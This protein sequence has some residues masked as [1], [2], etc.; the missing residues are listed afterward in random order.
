M[1]TL[2]PA[3]KIKIL[4][5]N[6]LPLEPAHMFFIK[7]ITTAIE[8]KLYQTVVELRSKQNIFY[9]IFNTWVK[10][11]HNILFGHLSLISK[12]TIKLNVS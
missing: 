9:K 6:T 8:I 10:M 4:K 1:L 12:T 3:K 7:Q 5:K 11:K 2:A